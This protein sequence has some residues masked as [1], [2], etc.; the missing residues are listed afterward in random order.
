MPTVSA[1]PCQLPLYQKPLDV[2]VHRTK[3]VG[4]EVNLTI[5]VAP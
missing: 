2:T 5:A 4:G 1:G 3:P